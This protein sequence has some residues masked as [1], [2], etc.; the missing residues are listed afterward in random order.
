L[1]D[2]EVSRLKQKGRAVFTLLDLL[3]FIVGGSEI[4]SPFLK[5]RLAIP[6]APVSHI[7]AS[8]SPNIYYALFMPI[9]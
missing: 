8:Q 2:T 9:Q 1:I 7:G 4:D 6:I 3:S 5:G